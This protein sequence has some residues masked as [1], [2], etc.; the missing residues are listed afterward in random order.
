MD[1]PATVASADVLISFSRVKASKSDCHDRTLSPHAS[2]SVSLWQIP[3]H[4]SPHSCRSMTIRTAN[5]SCSYMSKY[6]A[7]L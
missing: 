2:C 4:G 5:L 1:I 7:S 6:A 3:Q